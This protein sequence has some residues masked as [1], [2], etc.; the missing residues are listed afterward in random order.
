MSKRLV[1]AL[2]LCVGLWTLPAQAANK[3]FAAVSNTTLT[4]A[5]TE[6]SLAIP[7][8]T[9]AFLIKARGGE[10][11]KVAFISGQSGTTYLT[12]P[13]STSYWEEDMNLTDNLTLYAQ[14]TTAGVVLELIAWK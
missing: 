6:Y 8:Q 3:R 11:F 10:A 4:L 12:V 2:A 13:A 9:Q 5:N 7:A 14:S 1:L